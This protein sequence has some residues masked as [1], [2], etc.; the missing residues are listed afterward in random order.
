MQAS[1]SHQSESRIRMGNSAAD[2]PRQD[3]ADLFKTI[4]REAYIRLA[5]TPCTRATPA[6]ET[7]VSIGA[8]TIRNHSYLDG[9]NPSF[10]IRT[11]PAVAKL[12]SAY[13]RR[14]KT[15]LTGRSPSIVDSTH[16]E[17]PWNLS[18]TSLYTLALSLRHSHC[19]S[20]APYRMNTNNRRSPELYPRHSFRKFL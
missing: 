1:P 6:H 15:I 18:L 16:F 13:T 14:V 20:V 19:Q 9:R 7:P 5:F 2:L 12:D 4:R 3:P 17:K 10:G 11:I 8:F